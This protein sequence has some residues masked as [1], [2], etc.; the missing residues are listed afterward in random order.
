MPIPAVTLA[1]LLAIE[2]TQADVSYDQY[3]ETVLDVYAPAGSGKRPAVIV[4]HGGGWRAGEKKS[5]IDNYVQ[6]YF[7]KGFAVFNVEYRL[8]KAAIAPAAVQDALKAADWVR[9]NADKYGVDTK[10]IV[11]TGSSAGGHLSLMVGMTPKS[12]ALGPVG[13]VAAIVNCWGITDV[14]DQIEG[15]GERA[16]AVEWI[17]PSVPERRALARK[18]SPITYV[19]KDLP[20]VLT[21]HSDAD[22]TVPYEQGI[23]LTRALGKVDVQAELYCLKG[24]S[25]GFP[26]DRRAEIYSHVW[27]FLTK[28]GLMPGST[29]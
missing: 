17:P 10:R 14:E 23:M 4:I 25:H 24:A 12:A 19:R 1:M 13:K 27:P 21:I 8:A 9:R 11:V 2:P 7:D 15:P 18:L 28:L 16:Y 5:M 22:Q 20:P 29:N 26:A 3:K 6:P